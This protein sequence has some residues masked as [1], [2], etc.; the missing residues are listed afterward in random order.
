MPQARDY[1]D[2]L[3]VAVRDAE[4]YVDPAALSWLSELRNI[5]EDEIP[6]YTNMQLMTVYHFRGKKGLMCRGIVTKE[7]AKTWV[8]YEVADSSRPGC[9]WMIS[10]DWCTAENIQRDTNQAY[11]M[12]PGVRIK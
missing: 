4:K 8:V 1:L 9:R 6:E 11:E 3:E 12:A 5:V 2:Y 7:N 10:K